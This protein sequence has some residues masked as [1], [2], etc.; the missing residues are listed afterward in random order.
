M[1]CKNCKFFDAED[2]T[3]ED[4]WRGECTIKLPRWLFNTMG[5]DSY[6]P[7]TFMRADDGCDLG[8]GKE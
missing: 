6:N 3:T 4:A 2:N 7:N 1:I 8:K 5:I